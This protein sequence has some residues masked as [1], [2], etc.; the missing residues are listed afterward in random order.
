MLLIDV[1]MGQHDR[2]HDAPGEDGGNSMLMMVQ[3]EPLDPDG[4]RH[5]VHDVTFLPIGTAHHVASRKSLVMWSDAV[6]QATKP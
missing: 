2:W 4:L 3:G 5:K 6:C 1:V